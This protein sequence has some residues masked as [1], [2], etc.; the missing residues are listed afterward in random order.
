MEALPL[1][2]GCGVCS[3]L[4][5]D[6]GDMALGRDLLQKIED[7]VAAEALAAPVLVDHVLLDLCRC[8]RGDFVA[9]EG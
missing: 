8:W 7:Q 2:E 1:K 6:L 4:G 3:G 5:V 9:S